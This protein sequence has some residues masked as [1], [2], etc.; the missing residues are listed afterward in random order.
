M[1]AGR[2]SLIVSFL[3]KLTILPLLW[4]RVARARAPSPLC[5]TRD[6]ADFDPKF[7]PN[8]SEKVRFAGYAASGTNPFCPFLTPLEGS[9]NY[10][11][12]SEWVTS[13]C[14][15]RASPATH[16]WGRYPYNR[17]ER[18]NYL[19]GL[20]HPHVDFTGHATLPTRGYATPMQPSIIQPPTRGYTT[21]T[22]PPPRGGYHPAAYPTSVG[23]PIS[24]S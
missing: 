10:A 12:C 5:A 21:P 8:D 2:V 24:Q 6:Y 19:A 16:P 7:G 13:A 9:S 1:R 4:A 17:L 14:A 15:Q 20:Y 11:G 23:V 3:A 22:A 18:T